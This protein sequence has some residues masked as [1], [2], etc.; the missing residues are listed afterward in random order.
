[1]HL[2]EPSTHDTLVPEERRLTPGRLLPT[3][4]RR[5]RSS[6]PVRRTPSCTSS[7]RQIQCLR[8]AGR[9]LRRG[10]GTQGPRDYPGDH[11]SLHPELDIWQCMHRENISIVPRTLRSGR[12]WRATEDGSCSCP[13]C[14]ATWRSLWAA[15]ARRRA[16]EDVG[17]GRQ[18][19]GELMTEANQTTEQPRGRRGWRRSTSTIERS[20]GG[21]IKPAFLRS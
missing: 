16:D 8:I 3:T 19:A 2:D 15:I 18:G 20:R 9:D 5:P 17:P 1:M 21:G 11:R 10:D 13:T 6:G 4:V 14:S 12:S 7:R